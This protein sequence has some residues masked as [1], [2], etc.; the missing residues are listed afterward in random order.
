MCRENLFGE[1]QSSQPLGSEGLPVMVAKEPILIATPAADDK[2]I[3]V[4]QFP[5]ERLRYIVPKVSSA[6]TGKCLV[7]Y[8]PNPSSHLLRENTWHEV[9]PTLFLS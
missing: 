8:I 5:D 1:S 6:D 2:K 3:N 7:P 9:Q 4:Y